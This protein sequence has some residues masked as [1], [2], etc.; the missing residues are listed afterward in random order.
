[1]AQQSLALALR[2]SGCWGHSKLIIG[3]I[4]NFRL[5]ETPVGNTLS[6]QAYLTMAIHV[7]PHVC[8][9]FIPCQGYKQ[10]TASHPRGWTSFRPPVISTAFTILSDI[11]SWWSFPDLEQ[12]EQY[13][14]SFI[15]ILSVL[16]RAQSRVNK[17]WS[18]LWV[19]WCANPVFHSSV[20]ELENLWSSL[21]SANN[22]CKFSTCMEQY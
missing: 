17:N 12:E 19:S 10:A 21:S 4:G 11:L 9:N 15:S 16:T 20:K 14:C 22:S 8:K 13:S 1:M 2:A 3:Y 18:G 6:G 7:F 5:G